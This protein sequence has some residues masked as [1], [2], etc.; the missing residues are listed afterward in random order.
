[1]PGLA[2]IIAT[3]A[4]ATAWTLARRCGEDAL[5]TRYFIAISMAAGGATAVGV[6]SYFSGS[7]H[8]RAVVVSAAFAAG[9]VVG[10][11]T[12]V[13]ALLSWVGACTS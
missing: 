7:G 5:D 9:L 6:A 10:G 11:V 13:T 1:M 2:A 12:L 3:V 8:R 4:F